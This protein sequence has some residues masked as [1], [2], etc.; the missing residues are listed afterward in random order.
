MRL[1]MKALLPAMA[2]CDPDTKNRSEI[3]TQADAFPADKEQKKVI[4][5]HEQE[6][7]EDKEIQINEKTAPS[8]RHAPYSRGNK[9]ESENRCR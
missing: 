9:Y 4:A 3:G 6:H 1:T 2:L 7:E 8:P 5:H